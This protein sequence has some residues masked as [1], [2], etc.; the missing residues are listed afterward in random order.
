MPRLGAD[1][2]DG[3]SH[4]LEHP[5]TLFVQ[6]LV[7]DGDEERWL[8]LTEV[9]SGGLRDWGYTVGYVAGRS[10]IALPTDGVPTWEQVVLAQRA[11]AHGAFLAALAA[12]SV[13]L[14]GG[15]RRLPELWTRV[16]EERADYWPGLETEREPPPANAAINP[17][18]MPGAS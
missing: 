15:L 4:V 16:P 17:S 6:V 18:S 3:V 11:R 1:I 12:V 13:F 8:N 14:V 7:D 2:A 5:E 10:P 9:M